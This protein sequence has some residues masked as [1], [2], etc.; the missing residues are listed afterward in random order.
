MEVVL[1]SPNSIPHSTPKHSAR[2][3]HREFLIMRHFR[4]WYVTQRRAPILI[5]YVACMYKF[6]SREVLLPTAHCKHRAL[7]CEGEIPVRMTTAAAAAAFGLW[8]VAALTFHSRRDGV[9]AGRAAHFKQCA[10]VNY[11]WG[12]SAMR[13][14]AKRSSSSLHAPLTSPF[15]GCCCL[16]VRFS[17]S[18]KCRL[19]Y[20]SPCRDEER[21]LKFLPFHVAT[22]LC[23]RLL[24]ASAI[25][26]IE[27]FCA[28]KMAV[29][30]YHLNVL[31]G[32]LDSRTFRRQTFC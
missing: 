29:Y 19:L 7:T 9:A 15:A 14:F 32:Y 5:R 30:L 24:S 3:V 8:A 22:R 21:K 11:T 4:S 10:P 28:L 23:G 31:G 17:F 13:Q 25:F 16:C 27:T 18:P 2:F 12:R 20:C 26:C 1:R 6:Q